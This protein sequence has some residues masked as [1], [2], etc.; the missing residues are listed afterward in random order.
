MYLSKSERKEILAVYGF[1]NVS[2]KSHYQVEPDTWIYLF[3][4]DDRKYVLISAD[5]L[6]VFEFEVFPRLLKFT[7]SEFAELEFV[8]QREIHVKNNS[9]TEKASNIILFEYTD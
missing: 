8:L 1:D 9:L 2:E 5:Y 7:N 6:G 3:D 4:S